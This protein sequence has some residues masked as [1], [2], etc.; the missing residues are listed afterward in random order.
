MTWP[1]M[2]FFSSI[3][4]LAQTLQAYKIPKQRLTAVPEK[5]TTHALAGTLSAIRSLLTLRMVRNAT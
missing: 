2:A 1:A 4:A 3:R 5:V